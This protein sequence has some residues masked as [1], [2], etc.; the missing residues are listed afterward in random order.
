MKTKYEIGCIYK[1][2]KFNAEGYIIFWKEHV[3][4]YPDKL[5]VEMLK[6][7]EKI[8]EKILSEIEKLEKIE[9]EP[10]NEDEPPW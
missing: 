8:H 4:K 5:A 1:K 9:V 7:A 6:V 2:R 3:K 10:E